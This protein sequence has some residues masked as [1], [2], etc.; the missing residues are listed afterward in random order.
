MFDF[1]LGKNLDTMHYRD[2]IKLFNEKLKKLPDTE[3]AVDSGKQDEDDVKK[4]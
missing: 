1:Q 2:V 3:D 4:L